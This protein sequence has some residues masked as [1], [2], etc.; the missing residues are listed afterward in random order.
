ME[1]EFKYPRPHDISSLMHA[2]I[3]QIY[4]ELQT[5]H[6]EE[7]RVPRSR[8]TRWGFSMLTS[9]LGGSTLLSAKGPQGTFVSHADNRSKRLMHAT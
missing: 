9:C 1:T 7:V 3:P 8:R 2:G 4:A 5:L 6:L